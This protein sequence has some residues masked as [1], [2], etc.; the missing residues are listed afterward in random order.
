MNQL[1]IQIVFAVI[2]VGLIISHF[3]WVRSQFRK[4][5][6]Q[7]KPTRYSWA[8]YPVEEYPLMRCSGGHL[9]DRCFADQE[10]VCLCGQPAVPCTRLDIS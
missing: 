6:Q 2:L 4:H 9:S 3:L 10:H 7:Q 8:D 5:A 1:Y